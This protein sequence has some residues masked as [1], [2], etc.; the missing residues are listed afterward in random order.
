[1]SVGFF[2][3]KGGGGTSVAPSVGYKF[4]PW[5]G[6][7]LQSCLHVKNPFYR[8]GCQRS[9]GGGQ[10][11]EVKSPCPLPS[12]WKWFPELIP[13]VVSTLF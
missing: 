11:G 4:M 2:N 10:K 1:M 8:R 3:V 7:V 12:V 13:P 5:P 6:V 9:R